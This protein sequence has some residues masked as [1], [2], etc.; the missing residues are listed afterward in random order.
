[1]EHSQAH[2]QD[3]TTTDTPTL[4][5]DSNPFT[6]SFKGFGLLVEF[7]K[8]V[9]ITILVLGVLAFIGNILSSIG[10]LTTNS[11]TSTNNSYY[12][13][14][15]STEVEESV[16]NTSINL[17]ATAVILVIVF[18][19]VALMI[20]ISVV[21]S[22]AY[23]GFVAA[24]AVA[25][26]QRRMITV[27]EALSAMA[28]RYGVLFKSEL[29]ATLRIIGGFLLLIVPGIRAALR[30]QALPYYVMADK[31]LTSSQALAQTKRLYN[32]HL[33]EVFGIQFVGSLIPIIGGAFS[34]GGM[35]L[36]A[37]QLKE[38]DA[39]KAATPSTH[40]LNYLGLFIGAA[41]FLLFIGVTVLILILVGTSSNL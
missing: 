16:E 31:S 9:F 22:A 7:A 15:T 19:V 36:S 2:H 13:Y 3:T 17:A 5:Y 20:I 6:I 28:D 39:A 1:M 29:I 33:M 8:G 10:D 11:N 34:A 32:K 27:G 35:V 14:T 4:S 24:G 41:L 25:S 26:S 18:G 12:D 21:I 38:Y 30:Y 40:W 23:K 37:Q